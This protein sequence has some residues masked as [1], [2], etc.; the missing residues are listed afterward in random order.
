VFDET[1]DQEVNYS[2]NQLASA[3]LEK[4]LPAASNSVLQRFMKA[5]EENLRP[6]CSDPYGSYVLQ[7]LLLTASERRLVTVY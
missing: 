5:F 1:V 2:C 6:V 3:T 4:L 7:K